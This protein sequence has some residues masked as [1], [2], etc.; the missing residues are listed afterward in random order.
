MKPVIRKLL[1]AAMVLCFALSIS[2]CSQSCPPGCTCEKCAAQVCTGQPGCTCS[3]C[4]KKAS[5]GGCP[6]GCTKPCC[7]KA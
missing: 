6:A 2:G 3:A 1:T 5:L 4:A 7:K